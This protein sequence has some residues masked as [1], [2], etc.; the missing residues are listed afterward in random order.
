[1][2]VVQIIFQEALRAANDKVFPHQN[3]DIFM[4]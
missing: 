3:N 4:K 1:L 2:I